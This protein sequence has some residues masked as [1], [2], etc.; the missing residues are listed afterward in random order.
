MNINTPTDLYHFLKGHGLAGMCPE[1]NNF[2]NSMDVL[3]RMCECDPP[4]ARSA[5]IHS[6]NAQ[7]I[8]FVQKAQSYSSILLPKVSGTRIHFFVNG[9]LI[10]IVDR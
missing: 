10:T 7:Y 3:S 2:I 4:A 5:Q 8:N 1:A 9:Q 6:C